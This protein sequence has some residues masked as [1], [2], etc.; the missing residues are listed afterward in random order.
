M[1]GLI[2]CWIV[3]GV[4]GFILI[5]GGVLYKEWFA[6]VSGALWAVVIAG[7]MFETFSVEYETH[8][9]AQLLAHNQ[10][11]TVFT[12]DKGTYTTNGLYPDGTYMLTVDG[13]DVLVV[14]QAIDGAEG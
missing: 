13:D 9:P 12:T 14:W 10:T 1:I 5:V 11:Q 6:I 4:L 3:L 2:F 7:G 8:I